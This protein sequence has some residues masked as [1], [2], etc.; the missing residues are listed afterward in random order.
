VFDIGLSSL[1]PQDFI[2]RVLILD[3]TFA[4]IFPEDIKAS[5]CFT[6]WDEKHFVTD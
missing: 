5:E 2:I 4:G 1:D 3:P 6:F